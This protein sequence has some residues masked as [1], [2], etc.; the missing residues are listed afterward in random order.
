[1]AGRG[2]LFLAG[3]AASPKREFPFLGEPIAWPRLRLC[4]Y[5]SGASGLTGRPSM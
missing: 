3:W 2:V 5:L 1:M 4:R